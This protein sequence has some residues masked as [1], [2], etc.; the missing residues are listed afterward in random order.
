MIVLPNILLPS[1]TYKKN[2]RPEGLTY[3]GLV[4]VV[5]TVVQAAGVGGA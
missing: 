1:S 2:K 3:S 5:E 4:K